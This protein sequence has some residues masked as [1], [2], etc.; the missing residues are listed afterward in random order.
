MKIVQLQ[1]SRNTANVGVKNSQ[2]ISQSI[3]Y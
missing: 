3:I 2:S 1:D